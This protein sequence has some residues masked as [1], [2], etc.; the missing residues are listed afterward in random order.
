MKRPVTEDLAAAI[1]TIK[2]RDPARIRAA[3]PQPL[4]VV[5]DLGRAV[6][7]APAGRRLIAGDFSGIECRVLAW[8]SGQASKLAMWA[9]FDRTGGPG[10]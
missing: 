10:R 6:I 2:S 5:G 8:L 3:Y 4:A 7:C 1:E 9:K